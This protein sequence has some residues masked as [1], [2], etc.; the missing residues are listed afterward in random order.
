[1]SKIALADALKEW[2]SMLAA[3]DNIEELDKP[4]LRALRDELAAMAQA[5]KA[6]ADEQAYLEARRQA[7]TQ[8][9]RITRSH[10]LELTIKVKAA[11]KGELGHRN[12]LLTRFG[13]RPVRS[14]RKREE[15]GVAVYPR[16]DLLPA[17]GLSQKPT[18]GA[19]PDES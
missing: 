17:A 11:V 15:V 16:P 1:M 8:Q 2:D 12:E 5:V 9:L 18:G 14:R 4:A 7:V 13:I 19:P 10:G 6:L 3:L